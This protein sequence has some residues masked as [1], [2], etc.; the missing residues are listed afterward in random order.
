MSSTNPRLHPLI[1]LGAGYTGQFLFPLARA[2]GW[3]PFATSRNPAQHL[4]TIPSTHRIEFDLLRRDTWANIPDPAHLIWCFPI[5]SQTLARDFLKDRITS[6][7][8]FLLLGSTSA[9]GSSTDGL[10]DEHTPPRMTLPRVQVEESLRNRNRAIVLRLAG[11]YGPGR[12]VL[13]WMRKGKV[14]YTNRY[15]NL[16]HIEDVA[17]I[18]LRALERAKDGNVYIVSD[19]TPRRWSEIFRTANERWGMNLPKTS[20][21]KDAGKTTFH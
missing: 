11:L 21:A 4:S 15:V 14:K 19:G 2:A 10:I 16:V 5:P 3:D 18:C 7:C 9:Y 6:D 20:V 1:I 8:R 12:H 13:D 17:G